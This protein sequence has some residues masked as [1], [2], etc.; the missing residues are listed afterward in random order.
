[1]STPP[2]AAF[3]VVLLGEYS[4]DMPESPQGGQLQPGVG[5]ELLDEEDELM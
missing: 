2:L 3:S 4:R 1:V 5:V